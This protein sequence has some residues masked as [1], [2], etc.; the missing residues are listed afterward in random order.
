[1]YIR[2]V[3][4][5]L[6]TFFFAGC[7]EK[8]EKKVGPRSPELSTKKEVVP[9]GT[10]TLPDTVTTIGNLSWH[11]NMKEAF[12]LSQKEHK[13]IIVMIGEDNC[14]WCVKMKKKT[15][16]DPRVQ[17]EMQ[18]YILISIKR[19]DKE[20]VNQIAEFDGNIPSFFFMNSKKEVLD[21]VVGYF[22]KDDFF[23]YI[24]EMQE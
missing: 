2:L 18:K 14:R 21:S 6:L 15:L 13:E 10:Q 9:I 22:N 4:L 8:T 11:S 19:S 12:L 24:T 16:L 3:F 23:E 5:G 7:N 1:M 17:Q 20:A